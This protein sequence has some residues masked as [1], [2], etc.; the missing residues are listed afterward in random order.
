LECRKTN[1]T[2]GLA[3]DAQMSIGCKI[4]M[5][6]IEHPKINELTCNDVH[7]NPV[8]RT[9]MSWIIEDKHIDKKF[10]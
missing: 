7:N 9:F 2:L 5:L 10:G 3:D 8:L 6:L 1:R 4:S